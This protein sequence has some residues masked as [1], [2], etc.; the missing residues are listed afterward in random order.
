MTDETATCSH[1]SATVFPKRGSYKYNVLKI[2]SETKEIS[3]N[4]HE[5]V[6]M[7]CLPKSSLALRYALV[8]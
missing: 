2:M 5:V 4:L 1:K 8:M 7:M 3:R 6:V